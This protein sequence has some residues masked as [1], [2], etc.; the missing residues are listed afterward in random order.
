MDTDRRKD[1]HWEHQFDFFSQEHTIHGTN[2]TPPTDDTSTTTTT[3]TTTTATLQKYNVTLTKKFDQAQQQRHQQQQQQQQQQ[4]TKTDGEQDQQ[5]ERL[6]ETRATLLMEQMASL[7]G[8]L[9]QMLPT[10]SYYNNN[11]NNNNSN[12]NSNSNNFGTLSFPLG[13]TTTSSPSTLS[14]QSEPWEANSSSFDSH[15][16]SNSTEGFLHPLQAAHEDVALYESNLMTMRRQ[17]GLITDG[18]EWVRQVSH[19]PQPQPQQLQL[20]QQQARL[21]QID[22]A[23][24]SLLS[25]MA[26]ADQQ[27]HAFRQGFN[28]S[29]ACHGI[30]VALDTVQATMMQQRTMMSTV[31]HHQDV[32]QAWEKSIAQT[33]QQLTDIRHDYQ[34]YFVHNDDDDYDNNNDDH[35][36]YEDRW[37]AM[38]QRNELVKTWVEEVRVWFAEAERIRQWIDEQRDQLMETTLPDP[39]AP[40]LEDCYLDKV[41]EWKDQHLVLEK[42]MEQFDNQDMARLRSHVKT[43]TM[44]GKDLS[45]ADT[46]TIEITLTTLTT[47]DK[48]MHALRTKRDRLHLLT[49]RALWEAEYAKTMEWL[50]TTENQVDDFLGQARWTD[51]STD[52]K[53]ELIDGLLAL[54]HKLSEFDKTG[55]TTTVNLYQDFDDAAQEDLPTHLEQRQTNC[56]QFFEDLYKRMAYV[57]NVVEQRLAMME[58]MALV[59]Q[60]T[61]DAED[62]QL[63]LQQEA[64]TMDDAVLPQDDEEGWANRVQ[65][66]QEQIIPLASS[67]RIPYPVVTLMV[68]QQENEAANQV[69]RQYV[70]HHRT[71]LVLLGEAVDEQWQALKQRWHLQQRIKTMVTE[72]DQ[73]TG[74]A[75]DRLSVIQ[76]NHHHLMNDDTTILDQLFEWERTLNTIQIKLVTKKTQ[77]KTLCNKSLELRDAAALLRGNALNQVVDDMTQAYDQLEA[78]IVEHEKALSEG[79]QRLEQGHSAVDQQ[80]ELDRFI[81]TLRTSLPG[82]KQTC[83][84]MTGKSQSQDLDRLET[85]TRTVAKMNTDV[86]D[87]QSL[88]D[89]LHDNGIKDAWAALMDEM[90]QLVIFKDTV[91]EW[92]HRQRRLSLIEQNLD[93]K[94]QQQQDDDDDDDDDDDEQYGLE[95]LDLLTQLGQDIGDA[96]DTTDPL[97]TANYSCA[98]E[99]HYTLVQRAQARIDQARAKQQLRNQNKAWHTYQDQVDLWLAAIDADCGKLAFQLETQ[100]QQAW[101][102]VANVDGISDLV[103]VAIAGNNNN[104]DHHRSHWPQPPSSSG[105]SNGDDRIRAALERLDQVVAKGKRQLVTLKQL[106]VHAK[107]AQD[108]QVWLD[109][110]GVALGQLAMDIGV[111]DELDVRAS[112]SRFEAKLDNL[113]PALEG[114]QRLERKIINQQQQHTRKDKLLKIGKQLQDRFQNVERQLKEIG[115]ATDRHRHHVGV[116]RKMKDLLHM[117]GGYRDTLAA[118]RIPAEVTHGAIHDYGDQ[119]QQVQVEEEMDCLSPYLQTCPLS[120]IPTD[121]GLAVARSEL[122]RLE[123]DMQHN[124]DNGALH[125]LDE[126]LLDSKEMFMDQRKE[127]T[128]AITGLTRGIQDKRFWLAEASKL[129]FILTVLEE[130]EVL[131]SALTEVV[132]RATPSTTSTRADLQ[133]QLIDL[134]T[135]YRYYEPNVQGLLKEAQL[136]MMMHNNN[137]QQDG[138]IV[139]YYDQLTEQWQ[140]LQQSALVKKQ[141]LMASIGTLNEPLMMSA[142]QDA[143]PGGRQQQQQEQ[144]QP[145]PMTTMS[146]RSTMFDRGTTTTTSKPLTRVITPTAPPRLMTAERAKKRSSWRDLHGKQQQQQKEE[147]RALSPMDYTTYIADPKNDLDVALGNIVND[148]PYAIKVKMVPGEVGRYWFGKKNPKLAYCRILRSRMVMVRVGGG[149]VE[150]SQFLR[151]HA[152]LEEGR[153]TTPTDKKKNRHSHPPN[154]RHSHSTP[155]QPSYYCQSPHGIKNG[156]KFLVTDDDGNQVQVTMTKARS[157]QTT[158]FRTPWR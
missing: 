49:Q 50:H 141:A 32:V 124:L 84:F 9:G 20:L 91:Q 60:V 138:R 3:T 31:N 54:E 119:Q 118:I 16:S 59:D 103:Q 57:R 157:K 81:R 85:L 96:A 102:F 146:T 33:T 65:A 116:A 110:C 149:W 53:T 52:N 45:P 19:Q 12:S 23:Y 70:G 109:Q 75:K 139:A 34:D 94:Q 76:Q 145:R 92:Y 1:E 111:V 30:R 151:D 130:W 73:W 64:T 26:Q 117:I 150:L 48:V 72:A 78:M 37:L 27:F 29:Q 135:R 41:K 62:L 158:A 14:D 55:F 143:L 68:D 140:Q 148:L 107:A 97:Q 133:A 66:I 21:S 153:F 22:Q 47:L 126:A 152:L 136:V 42:D 89:Q 100:D 44:G 129:E 69:V 101:D 83:G 125:E 104:Y 80:K 122:D 105:E 39:L 131:L 56:E 123:Q 128:Q 132:D 114:F 18:M 67:Q 113:R 144:Q 127:I 2:D 15:H 154:L 156:N 108:L 87:R 35:Q 74:W 112:L 155:F 25:R 88:V 115:L 82:L 28:F 99:R 147:E 77:V 5:D 79:R 11:N 142:L 106:H 40:H 17:M 24:Q 98:K 86:A 38:Q 134:D 51:D 90:A 8:Q 4:P 6:F 121:Q 13:S 58:F 36:V 46:T 93:N 43:L 10:R 137:E 95:Q 7:H 61:L 120:M 71:Q 63:N